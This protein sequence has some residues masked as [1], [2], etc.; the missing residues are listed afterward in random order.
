MSYIKEELLKFRQPKKEDWAQIIAPMTGMAFCLLLGYFIGNVSLGGLMSLGLFV[1][2]YYD[3]MPLGLLLKRLVSIGLLLLFTMF[4][5]LLCWHFQWT[6]PMVIGGLAFLCRL[7]FRLYDIRQPGALFV[8]LLSAVGVGIETN[9]QS[10][11]KILEIMSLGVVLGISL[12][13]IVHFTEKTTPVYQAERISVK[14]RVNQD[15][16]ALMDALFYAGTL[17]FAVYFSM[18]IGLDKPSWMIFSCAGILQAKNLRA[19]MNRQIQRITGTVLGL[20]LAIMITSVPM[21]QLMQIILVVV[22]YG[23][24]QY[25][26]RVNYALGIFVSTPMAILLTTMISN[27]LTVSS[28]I[29]N[30]LIG[31][32]LGCVLGV[33]AAWLMVT[34]LKFYNRKWELELEKTEKNNE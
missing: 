17:F 32:I 4:V 19:M 18:G 30:R 2:F 24:L 23:T 1:F 5:S 12:A 7:L 13:V 27:K 3:P 28:A 22:L 26:I 10:M 31:I 34:I 16:G 8:I 14:E 33:A 29:S 6:A 25:C 21:S 11:I 20:I 15:P 9:F